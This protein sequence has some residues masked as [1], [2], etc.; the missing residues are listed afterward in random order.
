MANILYNSQGQIDINAMRANGTLP[1]DAY[2]K[3]DQE[4]VDVARKR[5][6]IVEDLNAFG[7]VNASYNLGDIVVKY[8]KI[9]N[10]GSSSISMDGATPAKRDRTTFTEAG[11]PL[12]IFRQDFTLNERQMQSGLNGGHD[13]GK[14][15]IT[16]A[17][18][19]IAED[20]HGMV[21]NGAP[22]LV[23]V[24]GLHLYGLTNHPDRNT[25]AATA[26]WGAGG[27]DPV[28][29]IENM[30]AAAYAKNF[31]GPFN[32]YVSLDHWAF[33]D[34]DYS[35]VKGEKT[36]KQ[37]FEAFSNINAV[38]PGDQL[39]NGSAVLV[40]MTNETIELK[41][42]QDLVNFQQPQTE[43]MQYDF[44]VMAAMAICVKSDANSNCGVVNL[45]GS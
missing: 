37:R 2:I 7:L 9:S 21:F 28:Q 1:H 8:E 17:T 26:A 39:A 41:V 33:I 29:D 14:T 32:L 44:T 27:S 35:A 3:W 45:T 6:T 40:N 30:L 19:N 23:T 10:V 43:R 18:K 31:F 12:P 16:G 13:L 34:G 22:D 36:Y 24:D 5:L 4:M 15:Y 25:V 38:R 20:I 11:V 42:A